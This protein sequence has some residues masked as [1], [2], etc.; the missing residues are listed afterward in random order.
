MTC[1]SFHLTDSIIDFPC[2]STQWIVGIRVR[3][4]CGK[5]GKL[6]YSRNRKLSNFRHIEYLLSSIERLKPPDFFL[7]D[8]ENMTLAQPSPVRF[9]VL[10]ALDKIFGV[11]KSLHQ[12]CIW[13]YL[14]NDKSSLINIIY[15]MHK[16]PSW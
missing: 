8:V 7:G 11:K 14:I 12:F 10:V 2:K 3:V 9:Q 16:V 15:L 6:R 13:K 5:V 4:I 1:T